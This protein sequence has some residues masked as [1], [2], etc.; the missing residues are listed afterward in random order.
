[1]S[2]SGVVRKDANYNGVNEA[3]D[4]P[5]ASWSLS[6]TDGAA[7]SLTA[8]SNADGTYS[9][10][11]VPAGTYTVCATA[12]GGMTPIQPGSGPACPNGRGWTV[13]V[14]TAPVAGVDFLFSLIEAG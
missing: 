11:S 3:T 9:F 1:L 14:T 2:V 5:L 6:L 4:A 10:P 12:Q 13:T 7:V 8:M